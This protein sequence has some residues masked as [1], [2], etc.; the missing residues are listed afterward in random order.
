MICKNGRITDSYY[1]NLVFDDGQMLYTPHQPLLKGV[2]R[3]YL[4]HNNQVQSIDI[5]QL[6][7]KH[8]H[9][10]HLINAMMDLGEC[11]VQLNNCRL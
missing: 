7:L 10:V 1:A 5:Q 3:E 8:F 2:K 9:Q 4:I 6:D 11:V